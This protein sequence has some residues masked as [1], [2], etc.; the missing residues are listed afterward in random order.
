MLTG[1]GGREVTIP[2]RAAAEQSSVTGKWV[3]VD[4]DAESDCSLLS[5]S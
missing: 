4:C 1:V 3:K 5:H 2:T